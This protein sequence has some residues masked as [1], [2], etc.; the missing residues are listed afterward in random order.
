VSGINKLGQQPALL[1]NLRVLAAEKA[2]LR[3][4]RALRV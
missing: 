2:V 1:E 4:Q 3:D